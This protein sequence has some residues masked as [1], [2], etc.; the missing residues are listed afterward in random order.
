MKSEDEMLVLEQASRALDRQSA[1]L[2]GVRAQSNA[3]TSLGAVTVG[4]LVSVR[5]EAK[6]FC[7]LTWSGLAAFGL[8]LL[9]GIYVAFPR[10]DR[11]LFNMSAKAMISKK[12]TEGSDW[13]LALAV[14]EQFEDS[15]DRNESEIGKLIWAHAAALLFVGMSFALLVIDLAIALS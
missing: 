13:S 4:L 3:L 1:K 6:P 8:V 9:A 11:W 7:W 15:Y 14:A 12:Q 10:R 2:D 5:P